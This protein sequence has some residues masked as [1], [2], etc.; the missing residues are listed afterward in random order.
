MIT[1]TSFSSVLYGKTCF[2]LKRRLK[3]NFK[4]GLGKD[5]GKI[6]E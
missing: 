2:Y 5:L 3:T 1:L 6:N 4:L